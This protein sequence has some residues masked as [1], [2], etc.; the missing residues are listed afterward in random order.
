M[1]VVCKVGPFSSNSNVHL[2]YSKSVKI[3]LISVLS[4]EM[5][6][7]TTIFLVQSIFRKISARSDYAKKLVQTTVLRF[8]RERQEISYLCIDA[9]HCVFVQY[10]QRKYFF[11]SV[12]QLKRIITFVMFSKETLFGTIAIL[13]SN[14]NNHLQQ[15]STKSNF[16]DD[17]SPRQASLQPF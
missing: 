9:V 3:N 6:N 2:T 8:C 4:I 5:V 1:T 7:T 17:L 13:P 11:I 14:V 12:I 16:N 15:A 10:C